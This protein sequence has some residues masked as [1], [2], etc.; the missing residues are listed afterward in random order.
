MAGRI[1]NRLAYGKKVTVEST[2]KFVNDVISLL[3]KPSEQVTPTQR[4]ALWVDTMCGS[5]PFSRSPQINQ[6]P[7]EYI[8]G[9]YG[10]GKKQ[11]WNFLI[12]VL[13]YTSLRSKKMPSKAAEIQRSVA[14]SLFKVAGLIAERAGSW[15]AAYSDIPI[16]TPIEEE[17]KEAVEEEKRLEA[18]VDQVKEGAVVTGVLA[19]MGLLAIKLLSG[20]SQATAPTFRRSNQDESA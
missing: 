8:V 11:F 14:Q 19:I 16:A 1:L 3:G 17:M 5:R 6:Q 10:D 7:E 18:K 15:E 12:E 20:N 4:L 2:E 13:A 9:L